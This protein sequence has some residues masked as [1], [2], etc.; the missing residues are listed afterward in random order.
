MTYQVA[1]DQ[2]N[3]KDALNGDLRANESSRREGYEILSMD[4][5]SWVIMQ[6]SN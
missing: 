6:G 5:G 1:Q 2:R 3:N 4:M